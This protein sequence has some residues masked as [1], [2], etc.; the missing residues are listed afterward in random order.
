M[1]SVRLIIEGGG[2]GRDADAELRE[3]M[4]RF[5]K[6]VLPDSKS[7][8]IIAAGSRNDAYNDFCAALKNFKD[9]YIILLVDSEDAVNADNSVWQHVLQRDTWT[10]PTG[11]T[12]EQAHLM[13]RSMECWFLADKPALETYFGKSFNVNALPK[14]ANIEEIDR[15]TAAQAIDNAAKGTAKKGYHK[16]RDG[17]KLIGRI[18]G[19]KVCS[20]SC[21][22]KEFFRVLKTK[23]K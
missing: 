9:N 18:D 2:A 22:A 10:Q 14:N 16:S 1:V 3:G 8:K 13:V 12:N 5:I 11:T 15:H 23:L 19:N 20:V 6:T 21:H 17:F 4:N 7:P